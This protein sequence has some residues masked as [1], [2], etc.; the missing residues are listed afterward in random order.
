MNT[1]HSFYSA[2]AAY[3]KYEAGAAPSL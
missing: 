2:A 3:Q 1:E